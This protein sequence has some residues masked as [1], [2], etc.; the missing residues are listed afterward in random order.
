MNQKTFWT[1]EEENWLKDN[2]WKCGTKKSSEILKKGYQA[3]KDKAY[4]LRLK[5][6]KETQIKILRS[7]HTKS[8]QNKLD[9]NQ[10]KNIKSEYVAYFLGFMWADGYVSKTLNTLYLH[11]NQKDMNDICNVLNKIGRFNKGF[12]NKNNAVKLR[13]NHYQLADFLKDHDYKNK[14]FVEPTKILNKIPKYLHYSFW[15]GFFDGDG[16]IMNP[17]T[18]GYYISFAGQYSYQWMCLSKLFLNNNINNFKIIRRI[19]NNPINGKSS[20][21]YTCSKKSV[22]FFLDYIYSGKKIIGLRRKYNR[23][24]EAK[25]KTWKNFLATKKRIYKLS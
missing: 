11:I 25:Y 19:V 21:F 13:M 5:I 17:K 10:F 3:V 22:L 12:E 6:T 7:K 8:N 2:Y 18:H 24:I 15:H 23:Y 20:I 9:M 1:L 4:R 14:S 16:H